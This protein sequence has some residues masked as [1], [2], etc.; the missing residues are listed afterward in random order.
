MND[1]SKPTSLSS[2]TI[3]RIVFSVLA[4]VFFVAPALVVAFDLQAWNA[5]TAVKG[6]VVAIRPEG[7]FPEEVDVEYKLQN[8]SPQQVTIRFN[9]TSARKVGDEV[10]LLM[11]ADWP[12]QPLTRIQIQD[13]GW[14]V[15][16]YLLFG[17]LVLST[18]C[19]SWAFPEFVRVRQGRRT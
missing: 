6:Q 1:K 9:Y 7:P 18:F 4:I 14:S 17:S 5:A 13:S 2:K 11:R 12:K 3:R 16:V 19:L 15:N 8:E 10:E